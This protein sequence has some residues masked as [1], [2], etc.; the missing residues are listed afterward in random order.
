MALGH[1]FVMIGW[2][3]KGCRLVRHP[4]KKVTKN[5]PHDI[6]SAL[7]PA[8]PYQQYVSSCVFCKKSQYPSKILFFEGSISSNLSKGS[9]YHLIF[10]NTDMGTSMTGVIKTQDIAV[11]TLEVKPGQISGIIPS[12]APIHVD[13]KGSGKHAVVCFHKNIIDKKAIEVSG[14][15]YN[16]ASFNHIQPTDS[17]LLVSVLREIESSLISKK[18]GFTQ[19]YN[20]SLYELAIAKILKH[21]STLSHELTAYKTH[22]PAQMKLV[23]DYIYEH[24]GEDLKVKDMAK[25][26]GVSPFHFSRLFKSYTGSPPHQYIMQVRIERAKEMLLAGTYAMSDIAYSLGLSSQSHFN[27]FFKQ[28]S[29]RT[30]QQF[31]ADSK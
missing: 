14:G 1:A 27:S 3:V 10:V 6:A 13:L 31:I 8:K 21:Y 19:L 4:L 20:E 12:G 9:P 30:P 23:I 22:S 17:P 29:G 5:M 2:F 28:H 15:T 7:L 16:H 25:I 18:N 11:K 24:I 26:I